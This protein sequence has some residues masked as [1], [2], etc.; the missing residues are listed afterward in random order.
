MMNGS[1]QSSAERECRAPQSR[2]EQRLERRGKVP[3]AT[4]ES[5]NQTVDTPQKPIDRLL[6][7]IQFLESY[8]CDVGQ[9]KQEFGKLME[10][11]QRIK[12]LTTTVQELQH[13]NNEVGQRLKD[14]SAQLSAQREIFDERET[15]LRDSEQSFELEKQ[16]WKEEYKAFEKKQKVEHDKM[17][18]T[19]KR[20][21]ETQLKKWKEEY[22]RE[23]SSELEQIRKELAKVRQENTD[24]TKKNENDNTTLQLYM[25]EYEKQGAEISEL[26]S[27]YS[28]QTLPILNYSSERDF[29]NIHQ[30]ITTIMHTYFEEL[31][32]DSLDL[33]QPQN[34]LHDTDDIFKCIPLTASNASKFLRI[35]G[36]QC[37]V[38]KAIY[39][40]IWQP[41]N[42]PAMPLGP[43]AGEILIQISKVVGRQD[44][45]KEN[46][47]RNITFQGLDSISQNHS[48]QV[49]QQIT[50]ILN[51]LRPLI[52]L[53]RH[54][55][56]N[57]D[58]NDVIKESV[59]LWDR[60]KRDSCI[61]EFDMQPPRLATTDWDAEPWLQRDSIEVGIPRENGKHLESWC[62]FPKI[63]FKPL[64]GEQSTLP[65]HALFVDSPAFQ[66]GL[67]E[68]NRQEEEIAQTRRNFARRGTISRG[69]H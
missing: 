2:R 36:A 20:T 45:N 53:N 66:E 15:S 14:E 44:R 50:T 34:Q 46:V 22:A 3:R 4:R 18:E 21:I 6:S 9:I 47:W 58:M 39:S 31:A 40:S 43:E 26:N 48:E 12:D 51:V 10:K 69:S 67:D 65:G 55:D 64:S 59:L 7:L 24:L 32:L 42:V 23:K 5:S 30:S 11:D 27:R 63:V 1:T 29:S 54:A 19:Q 8:D 13:S 28:V 62:L 57:R 25:K 52:P 68:L 37:I 17:V 41:F 61:V 49:Y 38:S 33:E 16:R 60:L 35:R 56:F